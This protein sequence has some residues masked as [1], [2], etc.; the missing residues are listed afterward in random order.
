[1]VLKKLLP[2]AAMALVGCTEAST[3]SGTQVNLTLTQVDAKPLPFAVG[4]LTAGAV[5]TVVNSGTLVG[6][7]LGPD[8][9]ITLAVTP[10]DPLKVSIL[11]CTIN[12]G[13]RID[14]PIDFGNN[15]GIHLYRFQ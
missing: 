3:P 1:M 5:N 11:P 14:Y 13:D 8:C 4:A 6:N 12:K 7:D 15:T 2:I 9:T 10:G